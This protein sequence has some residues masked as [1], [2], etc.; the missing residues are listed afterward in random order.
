MANIKC[1]LFHGMQIPE[2][3]SG[4]TGY[5]EYAE[6]EAVYLNGATQNVLVGTYYG[7]YNTA[8]RDFYEG[9]YALDNPKEAYDLLVSAIGFRLRPAKIE[10]LDSKYLQ[11]KK[12]AKR[13]I[14]RIRKLS[15][16]ECYRLMGCSDTDI[17][18]MQNYPYILDGKGG[19]ILP[20][21]MTETE[22]KKLKISESQQY[23]LAGNSIVVNV[24]VG[25]FTQMFRA[26][27]DA[28][29]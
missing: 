19:W 12:P 9:V 24:L 21:G 3:S 27:S 29:F 25:I 23:K 6:V 2:N 26:D 11:P 8:F 17:D 7:D 20:E 28:L 14:Y 1:I 22:A 18:L 5:E 4:G 16:R 13:K 15:P 10:E